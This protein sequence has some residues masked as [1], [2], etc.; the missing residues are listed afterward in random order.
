MSAE[1]TVRKKR[2]EMTGPNRRGAGQTIGL[3]TPAVGARVTGPA[4]RR[5]RP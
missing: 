2:E 1:S 4:G 3:N 5:Q